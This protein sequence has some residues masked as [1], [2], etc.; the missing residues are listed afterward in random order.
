MQIRVHSLNCDFCD[1]MIIWTYTY[2]N[3]SSY[4]KNSNLLDSGIQQ[5]KKRKRNQIKF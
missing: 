5:L 2:L 4:L 1:L 3:F